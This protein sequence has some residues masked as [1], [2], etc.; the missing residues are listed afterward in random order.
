M[1]PW[2]SLPIV[3]LG[4]AYSRP[5]AADVVT[6]KSLEQALLG[7]RPAAAD[8]ARSSAASAQIRQAA[9]AYYPQIG[10]K[11][12]GTLA[13][14]RALVRVHK[15]V[16]PN[17][18]PPANEEEDRK[19]NVYLVQGARELGDTGAFTPQLR[20]GVDLSASANL[21][22]FGR[23]R[24]AVQA[25]RT[26]HAAARASAAVTL[27]AQLF[28]LRE[29]YLG[30]LSVHEQQRL[31]QVGRDDSTRRLERVRALVAEGVRPNSDVAP[32]ETESLLA[33]LELTR[34]RGEQE[35]ARL[36]LVHVSGQELSSGAAPDASL[37]DHELPTSAA[38]T[39]RS[40]D[41]ALQLQR[42]AATRRHA[43]PRGSTCRSWPW[44]PTSALPS[45]VRTHCPAIVPVCF[46]PCR[47]GTAVLPVPQAKSTALV[48]RS[49]RHACTNSA[50]RTP[51]PM[52][53]LKQWWS[54]PG[55][56][57]L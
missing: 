24:A 26:S 57:W 3:L 30:W 5:A 12:T 36:L 56:S 11:G 2:F 20:V 31:A 23:T 7:S 25:A 55:S 46:C 54:K 43:R 33:E 44:P 9:A 50:E 45:R 52:S 29:A 51:S 1:L 8:E 15:Y 37:L 42:D 38:D 27:E 19:K 6:L 49:W 32:A 48:P 14:G 10:L 13:P 17:D 4:V 18:P 16:D 53:A 21:Y 47:C 28:D 39:D 34:A 40:A 22:D 35:N 41:R